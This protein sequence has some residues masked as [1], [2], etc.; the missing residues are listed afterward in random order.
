MNGAPRARPA[1]APFALRARLLPAAEL[2]SLFSDVLLTE[3]T[4]YWTLIF[5]FRYLLMNPMQMFFIKAFRCVCFAL[6]LNKDHLSFHLS[7]L[8]A[9]VLIFNTIL[10]QIHELF[11]CLR[12]IVPVVRIFRSYRIYGF[13][14]FILFN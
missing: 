2:C 8:D 12:F 6:L 11:Y 13:L 10:F 3:P 14:S 5:F 4:N 1:L 7:V 9:F